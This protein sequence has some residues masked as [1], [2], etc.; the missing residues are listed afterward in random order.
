MAKTRARQSLYAFMSLIFSGVVLGASLSSCL[1]PRRALATP[2]TTTRA[3]KI[4]M[5]SAISLDLG[6]PPRFLDIS[7]PDVVDV[8][9]IGLTN[10]VTIQAKRAGEA[11]IL[12]SHLDGRSVRY[13]VTVVATPGRPV[14]TSPLVA[15]SL[16]RIAS[17]IGPVEGVEFVIDQGRVVLLGHVRGS[18]SFRGLE[19]LVRVAGEHV[20]PAFQITPE[21]ETYALTR[22]GA[23]MVAMGEK[24][25]RVES[26][27]GFFTLKGTPASETGRK[28]AWSFVRSLFPGIVDATAPTVGSDDVVQVSLQFLEVAR[29]SRLEFGISPPGTGAPLSADAFFASNSVTPSFQIAPV[30][31]LPRALAQNGA[32]RQLARPVLLTR[33]GEKATFLAGG[34]IPLPT[35]RTGTSGGADIRID[36]KPYGILFHATPRRRANDTIWL[37]LLLEVSEVDEASAVGGVPGFRTRKVE[38]KI[39]LREA[40]TCVFT[41]LVQNRDSKRVEKIP[42]LGDIPIL[43]ELFKSRAFRDDETELWVAVEATRRS[44]ANDRSLESAYSAAAK[45]TFGRLND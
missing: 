37:D 9:R 40:Q 27:G 11:S 30:G 23:R 6:A 34:E 24:G 7:E 15:S 18:K 44:T 12:V 45:L 2:S 3:L 20:I 42:F 19:S 5:G 31:L 4:R 16:T 43:G 14:E 28:A 41:G 33:E 39:A 29:N 8:A 38:T 25:L 22:A 26:S 13:V 32:S 1:E 36:F 17:A 35:S 10:K 21:A